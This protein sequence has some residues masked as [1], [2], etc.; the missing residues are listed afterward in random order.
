M[1]SVEVLIVVL[2]K[3]KDAAAVLSVILGTSLVFTIP[4][5]IGN[6]RSGY[7][8]IEAKEFAKKLLKQI[9]T[10]YIPVWV[11]L[12][13]FSFIPS[14]EDLWKVRISLLKYQLASPENIEKGAEEIGRLAKKLECKYLGCE[15]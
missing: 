5:L 13:L 1:T 3:V 11:F 4:M 7:V 8:S 12:L 10:I 9:K 15:E 2:M 14:V 6:T